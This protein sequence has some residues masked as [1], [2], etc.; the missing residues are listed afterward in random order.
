MASGFLERRE[1]N[2]RTGAGFFKKG[3]GEVT[4]SIRRAVNGPTMERAST[5]LGPQKDPSLFPAPWESLKTNL[6]SRKGVL[7]AREGG[8]NGPNA[9]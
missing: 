2:L 1:W 9:T 7:E 8:E 4:F 3:G 5:C 6:V